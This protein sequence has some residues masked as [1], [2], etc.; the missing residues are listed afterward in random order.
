MLLVLFRDMS[1]LN[2]YS[3]MYY[4]KVSI[5]RIGGSKKWLRP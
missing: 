5:K 4:D 3:T 1:T 2:D